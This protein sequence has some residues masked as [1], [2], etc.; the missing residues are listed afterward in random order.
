MNTNTGL[1]EAGL[2]PDLRTI[3]LQRLIDRL[4]ECLYGYSVNCYGSVIRKLLGLV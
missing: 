4:T 1:T 3:V 2:E